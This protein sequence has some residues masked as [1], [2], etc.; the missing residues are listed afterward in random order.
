MGRLGLRC[1]E[2]ARL[3]LDEIDWRAGA[4]T[5]YGK[6]HRDDQLPLPVDIGRALVSYLRRGRPPR[7]LDRAVFI[8]TL[9][10]HR[11]MGSNAVS[12]VVAAAAQRVGLP[13][14]PGRSVSGSHNP[15]VQIMDLTSN[16]TLDPIPNRLLIDLKPFSDFCNGQHLIVRHTR[17]LTEDALDK[18]AAESCS[19]IERGHSDSG[20][21]TTG[22][23]RR[24]LQHG[25]PASVGGA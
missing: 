7:A 2:I 12:R 5:I 16:S 24:A 20:D 17:I 25:G 15:A 9:A 10:P 21:R 1:G 13:P 4:I 14:P 11:A 18:L 19:T 6:G 8:R 3:T 23:R 22:H